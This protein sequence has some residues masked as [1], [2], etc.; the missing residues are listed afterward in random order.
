LFIE[1]LEIF[2][3]GNI[4]HIKI[5]CA[6]KSVFIV[7]EN[8]SGKS[9]ILE[10]LS[11]CLTGKVAKGLTI[12][13]YI[14]QG[15]KDF[16]VIVKTKDYT[17]TRT[18]KTGQIE[19]KD[20]RKFTKMTDVY[21][22]LPF[23]PALAFN[24]T[25]IKQ[26]D[27]NLFFSDTKMLDKL[28]SMI[29]DFTK[30]S[31]GYKLVHTK[32]QQETEELKRMDA[33]LSSSQAQSNI[34]VK[35]IEEQI[36]Q[37][38]STLA[39]SIDK[40]FVYEQEK[41]HNMFIQLKSNY[42][43]FTQMLE[44]L[45]PVDKPSLSTQDALVK[46]KSTMECSKLQDQMLEAT[47]KINTVNVLLIECVPHILE[48]AK[49]DLNLVNQTYSVDLLA[50]CAK[51]REYIVKLLTTEAHT[52]SNKIDAIFEF[53]KK[54]GHINAE[55]ILNE[56]LKYTNVMKVLDSNMKSIRDFN[57][58][59][60][61]ES[62]DTLKTYLSSLLTE[63]TNQKQEWLDKYYVLKRDTISE[64]EFK[65]I[66]EQNVEYT[67]YSNMLQNINME[68]DKIK[69]E[70]K[71]L[72]DQLKV[73]DKELEQ[74][75]FTVSDNER[76]KQLIKSNKDLLD[77]Q[78]QIMDMITKVS[79]TYD[80]SKT[81][82][83]RLANVKEIL[84]RLPTKLRMV[85]LN[86]IEQIVNSEFTK[87]FSFAALE[88]ISINW[89]DMEIS[90]GS[91]SFAALS[92]AQKCIVGMMLRMSILQRLDSFIPILLWDEPTNFMDDQRI[93]QLKAFISKL[94]HTV[95]LF[96]CTHNLDIVDPTTGVVVSTV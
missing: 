30:I 10:A 88:P 59:Q 35:S 38:E 75:K 52:T 62:E 71:K 73:T 64:E 57:V 63:Y 4:T 21:N 50:E 51:K 70:G 46:Y 39:S 67:K 96:I 36:I 55:S 28:L 60:H 77:T 9:N 8:G 93:L 91:L 58:L 29:F 87:S 49:I 81:V 90:S 17:I 14:R 7:G 11:L 95:Q 61:A 3:F 43:K 34:D 22:N 5:E 24:L 89:E 13:Q 66:S 78:T 32:L 33:I 20:G 6:Q 45:I 2:D 56:K 18:S 44:T 48:L 27:M 40:D 74:M 82:Q 83:E 54:Y 1:E 31:E 26:G 25:Y 94:S 80:K 23:D 68:I 42:T 53:I 65:L 47:N 41:L 15:M 86:P 19:F 92:G 12:S 84:Y 76:V 85:I 79:T 69:I 72:K 37:L 16:K